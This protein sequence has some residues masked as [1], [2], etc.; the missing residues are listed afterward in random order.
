M[1]T[2][3]LPVSFGEKAN[4]LSAVKRNA[5]LNAVII[6]VTMSGCHCVRRPPNAYLHIY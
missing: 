6:Y 3:L 5:A 2:V 1:A 4:A